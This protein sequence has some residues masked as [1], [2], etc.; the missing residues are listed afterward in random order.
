MP[1]TK[2]AG[3]AGWRLKV[4]A[5]GRLKVGAG[6]RLKVGAGGRLKVG[7]GV[8]GWKLKVEASLL[9][10]SISGQLTSFDNVL[11]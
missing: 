4:G 10:F 1:K 5:G 6:G 11:P 9:D 8:P 7:A 3:S 2:L